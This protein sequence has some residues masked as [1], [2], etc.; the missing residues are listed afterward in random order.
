M[1]GSY[2]LEI[3][4]F[5]VFA[6]NAPSLEI[7]EDGILDS[8]HAVSASG[9]TI[10]VT[11]NY[12]G[13]LPTSLALTFNDGFAAAGRTIEIR[14]VK[15]NDMYVNVGNYLSSDSLTKGQSGNVDVTTSDYIFDNSDPAG[16]EFTAV[17]PEW[18]E[19]LNR[20]NL[21]L[22]LVSRSQ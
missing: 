5:G 8:T 20:M 4:V 9:T 12:G 16:A 15:I 6:T 13:A 7:W 14:S 18:L 21:N 19:G 22:S 11:I 1:A 2:T 17:R 10:S 3:E